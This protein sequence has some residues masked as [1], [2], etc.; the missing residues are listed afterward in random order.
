MLDDLFLLV[1]HPFRSP[2]DIR[3]YTDL[4]SSNTNEIEKEW[5]PYKIDQNHGTYVPDV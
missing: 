2:I 5:S 1:N 4:C 3:F